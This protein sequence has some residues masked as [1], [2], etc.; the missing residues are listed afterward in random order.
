[1]F[2]GLAG[3]YLVREKFPSLANG[4][5]L[6]GIPYPAYDGVIP[7]NQVREL[8]LAIQDRSFTTDSQL[9]YP[10][11]AHAAGTTL[12]TGP[13]HPR[14]IPEYSATVVDPVTNLPVNMVMMAVNGRTYPKHVSHTSGGQR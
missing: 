10:V 8:P 7:I 14:W 11:A 13:L 1:V 2:A 5:E 3:F 12:P 6:P 4:P 9:W